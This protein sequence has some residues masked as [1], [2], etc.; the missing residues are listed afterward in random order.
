MEFEII[1]GINNINLDM[2]ATVALGSLLLLFGNFLKRKIKLLEK[3]CIPGPVIGGLL[4]AII[5]FILKTSNML[6]ISMDTTLQSPFMIAFFTTIG[7]GASFNL[8]K[9]GGKLLIIY[10][11][12]CGLLSIAQNLIGVIGAKITNINPLIGIMCGAVSMEGGHGAA[13][14]FGATIE[15][16][17]V[18]GAI[19]IGMA[20]ATFGIMCGGLIGGPISRYLID[21][22]KLTPNENEINNNVSVEDVAGIKLSDSFNSNT[23][24]VQIAVIASCMTVGSV[25]G[26]WFSSV[27][28]IVL[29]GYVGAMFIAVIFRNI[30]DRFKIIDLDLY[31]IDI[32]SNICLGIFLTMALMTIK[33]WELSGLAGP[34]IVIVA[35]Q[36]IFIALYGVFIAFRV[37]GKDFDAAI[38]VSGMLGHGLG[39]TPNAL[40]N[41]N[42]VTSKYG[43]STKAFLIVPLVGAFLIDLVA[44][45]TIVTF[46][47]FFS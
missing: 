23:M 45:P 12:L 46:I 21:K 16:L 34:M 3:F 6:N 47:N 8:L 42:S 27:T 33:L 2:I 14:S 38:M 28:K 17:G 1:D 24:I 9:K 37:L 26:T 5:I 40:A 35:S 36:V 22:Y 4:F 41:I 11:I 30:N 18:N 39:A 25:V 10:W 19:T 44:I 20:A 32:I 7:L 31:S 29:P 15:S 43:N 13:A